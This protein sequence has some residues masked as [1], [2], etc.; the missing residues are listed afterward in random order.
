LDA[1]E[2]TCTKGR[3]IIGGKRK[4]RNDEFHDRNDRVKEIKMGKPYN[5]HG[6][7]RDAYTVVVGKPKEDHNED[8]NIGRRIILK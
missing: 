3:L 5:M 6:N 8:T 2:N 4:L 7:N 1:E